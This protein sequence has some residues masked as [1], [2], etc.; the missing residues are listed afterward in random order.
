M[1]CSFI[2]RDLWARRFV[3]RKAKPKP[4]ER[5]PT[6]EEFMAKAPHEKPAHDP[7]VANAVWMEGFGDLRRLRSETTRVQA[8]IEEAFERIEPEDRA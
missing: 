6:L 1:A 3:S 4:G 8:R 7:A 5:G 2:R